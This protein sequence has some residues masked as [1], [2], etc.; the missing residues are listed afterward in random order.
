MSKY[1]FIPIIFVFLLSCSDSKKEIQYIICKDSLQYWDLVSYSKAK[2]ETT[3]TYCFKK[4]GS[5][6]MYNVSDDGLRTIMTYG[7]GEVAIEKW[8]ISN[9]SIFTI[10]VGKSKILKYNLDTISF[11]ESNFLIRVKGK[12]NPVKLRNHGDIIIKFKPYPY[13]W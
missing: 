9:D 12:I 11:G 10:N 4:D 5:Y 3:L 6:T 1:I 2:V 13:S 8:S 7:S